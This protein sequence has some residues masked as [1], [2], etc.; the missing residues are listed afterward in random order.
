MKRPEATS[1]VGFL[2]LQQGFEHP[3]WPSGSQELNRIACLHQEHFPKFSTAMLFW[4]RIR[5]LQSIKSVKLLGWR[6]ENLSNR[7]FCMIFKAV[8]S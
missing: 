5:Q 8:F 4:E 7:A 6:S 2:T 1:N 3:R